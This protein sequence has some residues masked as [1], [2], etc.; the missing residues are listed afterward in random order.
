MP[1]YEFQCDVCGKRF[2]KIVNLSESNK[3]VKCDCSPKAFAKKVIS[4]PSF[5]LGGKGGMKQTLKQV[6]RKI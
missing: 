4:A 5:R 2:E 6:R 1:I 3:K